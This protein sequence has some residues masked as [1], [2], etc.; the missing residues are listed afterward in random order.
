MHRLPI[1][2]RTGVLYLQRSRGRQSQMFRDS[3]WK[4]LSFAVS[5]NVAAIAMARR[6]TY[7]PLSRVSYVHLGQSPKRSFACVER[8]TGALREMPILLSRLNLLFAGRVGDSYRQS[9]Y[10]PEALQS[11]WTT[12]QRD[13]VL[14]V[15]S[16]RQPHLLRH[17]SH[18]LSSGVSW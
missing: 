17:L 10:L 16:R 4:A 8:E 3:L 2:S 18:I 6:S 1:R 13:L 12:A 5:E 7:V 11:S 9:S 14:S 15:H